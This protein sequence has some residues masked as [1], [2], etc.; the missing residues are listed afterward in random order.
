MTA[1]LRR[2]LLNRVTVRPALWHDWRRPHE[3]D[4]GWELLY[5]AR[6]NRNLFERGMQATVIEADEDFVPE[7]LRAELPAILQRQAA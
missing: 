6:L 1:L 3:I 7:W 5:R 4:K 2:L